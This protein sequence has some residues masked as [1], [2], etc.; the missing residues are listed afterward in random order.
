M[1]ARDAIADGLANMNTKWKLSCFSIA[2]S[3]P[4]DRSYEPRIHNEVVGDVS[5]E[6]V[7]WAD[8][9]EPNKPMCVQR[10]NEAT[11]LKH[12]QFQV[13]NPSCQCKLPCVLCRCLVAY[14][15]TSYWA[16]MGAE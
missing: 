16:D 6:E 4:E 7:R 14:R 1:S 13:S 11:R 9:Q 5:F 12:N 15:T 10:F 2:E 3:A 8:Y